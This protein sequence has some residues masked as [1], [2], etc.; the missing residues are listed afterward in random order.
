MHIVHIAL[1]E[2]AA[3]SVIPKVEAIEAKLKE[4]GLSVRALCAAAGVNQSTWTR[5]KS[6][7]TAPNMTTWARVEDALSSITSDPAA[8]GGDPSQEDAA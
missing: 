6:G 2:G 4:S 5:W 3:M 7:E 8:S 1:N